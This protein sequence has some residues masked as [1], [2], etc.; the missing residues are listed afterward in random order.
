[1]KKPNIL[2][3]D[4]DEVYLFVTKKIL[5]NLSSELVVNAFTDGEQAIE[6][7]DLCM[8]ENIE[9]PEIILLDINM[10][11]M[12][13]WGF[14][15]EFKKM[16][17]RLADQNLNIFMVTS[18]NDPNDLKKA[19]DFE[20]ITGYVVKPVFEDKLADILTEVFNGKW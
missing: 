13:G 5:N 10:P 16:K 12:D 9:L 3:V 18:S 2:L 15:A 8:N 14:L 4:D 17:P 6:Y 19:Q 7:I 11:F 20:E 1:M